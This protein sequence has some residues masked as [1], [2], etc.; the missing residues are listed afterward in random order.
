MPLLNIVDRR[1]FPVCS[2]YV[3]KTDFFFSLSVGFVEV[4]RYSKSF[5]LSTSFLNKMSTT[6]LIYFCY[7]T[8]K[9]NI[10]KTLIFVFL[11]TKG[12][13]LLGRI[14]LGRQVKEG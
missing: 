6:F 8:I 13:Y 5:M 11:L 1:P 3:E 7:F 12:F 10:C 4:D 9:W 14:I 2:L